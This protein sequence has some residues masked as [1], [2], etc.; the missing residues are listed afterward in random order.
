MHPFWMG[1]RLKF[2]FQKSFRRK[3]NY[4]NKYFLHFLE[5][6]FPEIKNCTKKYMLCYKNDRKSAWEKTA[7][8]VLVAKTQKNLILLLLS[9]QHRRSRRKKKY[10]LMKC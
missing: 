2:E 4:T 5:K 8:D 9:I 10:Q 3:R 1:V 7:L 6:K